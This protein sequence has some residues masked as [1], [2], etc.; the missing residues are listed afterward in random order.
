MEVFFSCTC[1][2]IAFPFGPSF[3]SQIVPGE[4]T[5]RLLFIAD[6]YFLF[7]LCV[8]VFNEEP[9]I[10]FSPNGRFAIGPGPT[11][12]SQPAQNWPPIPKGLF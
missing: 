10:L 2:K 3:T 1:V 6:D 7:S 5:V 12:V 9:P 11:L 4:N 8:G